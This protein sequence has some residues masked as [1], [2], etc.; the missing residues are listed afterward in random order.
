MSNK[1]T[2]PGQQPRGKTNVTRI[3]AL[4]VRPDGTTQISSFERG[5]ALPENFILNGTV[6][7]NTVS[8]DYVPKRVGFFFEKNF[9]ANPSINS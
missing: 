6:R 7:V 4:V 8:F 3:V 2:D 9:D 5:D 1:S